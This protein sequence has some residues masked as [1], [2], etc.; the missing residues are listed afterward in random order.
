M[1]NYT[2]RRLSA[3]ECSFR[4]MASKVILPAGASIKEQHIL[5]NKKLLENNKSVTAHVHYFTHLI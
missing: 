5:N 3:E 2:L 4:E 1:K